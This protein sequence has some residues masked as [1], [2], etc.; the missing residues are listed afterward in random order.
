MAGLAALGE[1]GVLARETMVTTDDEDRELGRE[2]R[3]WPVADRVPALD[4]VGIDD[5]DVAMPSAR[6]SWRAQGGRSRDW[7]WTMDD[8]RWT[9]D[10]GR[11]T[12]GQAVSG[13]SQGRRC[14]F[15]LARIDRSRS[16]PL[17]TTPTSTTR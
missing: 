3:R 11:W 16:L 13:S 12:R 7:R 5:M 2:R 15:K 6:L 9:M 14:L 4:E 8:G 17:L 10:D 1:S